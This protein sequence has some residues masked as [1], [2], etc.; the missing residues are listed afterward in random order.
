MRFGGVVALCIAASLWLVSVAAASSPY[1]NWAAIVVAGDW[2]S[3]NGAPSAAFD[4]ARRDVAASLVD[5]GFA[6]SNILQFSVRPGQEKDPGLLKSDVETISQSLN[7]LTDRATGGCLLYFTSHWKPGGLA[8]GNVAVVP[9]AMA[10]L[11]NDACGSRPT[12]IVVSACYSGFLIPKLQAPNRLIMTAARKDR[13]SFGCGQGNRYPYFDQCVLAKLP[14]SRSF[15]DLADKVRY[16][17]A[18]LE[19]KRAVETPSEPQLFVGSQLT[20][21]LPLWR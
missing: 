15:E 18:S 11:V 7:D 19:Q 20:G 3:L 8:I 10:Q 14:V 13:T 6:P 1:A 16:C 17:V 2:R 9:D 12:V 21:K 4:N 5:I